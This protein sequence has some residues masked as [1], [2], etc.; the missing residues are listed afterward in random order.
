[1]D[2]GV[3]IQWDCHD[4]DAIREELLRLA[5]QMPNS[6]FAETTTAEV[7]LATAGL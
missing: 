3:S 1:M 6:P 4:V 2:S 7:A 5:K